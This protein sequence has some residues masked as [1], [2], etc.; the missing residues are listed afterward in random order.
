[1][2]RKLIFRL[3]GAILA[4]VALGMIPSLLVALRYQ[5]GDAAVLAMC[6]GGLLIPGT[7]IWFLVRPGKGVHLR[8]REGFL[9]V[10][11]GWLIFSVGGALPFFFSGLYPRFEDALFESVSGFTTTGATVLVHFEGFPRGLMLWR[12]TT[13]WMGGMGVLMLTLALLPKLTGR[14][15]HLVRAESPGPSLSK[16]VPHTATT[17]K[18][19]YRIYILL[20]FMEFLLLLLCGLSTY[21]AAI[22]S[23]ST[24]GTGGFSNYAASVGAFHSPEAE[25]VITAFMFIFGVNFALYYRFLISPPREKLLSFFRDEEFRWYLGFV[26]SFVLLATFVNLSFYDNDFLRS[27]RYT[28]FHFSSVFS[29]TGFVTAAFDQWPVTSK[30]LIFLAMFIGACAGSTAGGIKVIRVALAGKHAGRAIRSTDQ[31]KKVQVV[32]LDGKAVDE[33]MLSQICVFVVVYFA[34]VLLGGFLLSLEGKFTVMENLSGALTCVSNVGPAFGA[35]AAD[36]TGYGTWGKLVCC[37]LMLA[38]RLEL[39]PMLFLFTRFAWKSH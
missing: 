4:I 24:A 1:M 23:L 8:L 16:L 39:F 25:A 3:M 37:F 22:H 26:V 29:T 5:D 11:L 27:F 32:R 38:G 34:L 12:A 15:S 35:L 30:M 28:A 18:I 36:F 21:D 19:L 10:A 7:A 9:V 31:P 6:C 17:A 2:N 33:S 14:T 13:H 20:T